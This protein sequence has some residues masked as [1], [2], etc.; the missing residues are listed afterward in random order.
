[1]GID[2]LDRKNKLTSPKQWYRGGTLPRTHYKM[3]IQKPIFKATDIIYLQV[4]ISCNDQWTRHCLEADA[5]AVIRQ[6]QY[7][8]WI[9]SSHRNSFLNCVK[10]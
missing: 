2:S 6:C 3:N 8:Q 10:Y 7:I 5:S 4:L 1:M 9:I